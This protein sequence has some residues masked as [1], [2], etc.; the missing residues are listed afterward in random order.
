LTSELKKRVRVFIASVESELAPHSS[1]LAPHPTRHINK[2]KRARVLVGVVPIVKKKKR[3]I[4]SRNSFIDSCLREED[5]DDAFADL[6]DFI[7]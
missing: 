2:K 3:R 4:R 5:G 6:E 1:A 7:E